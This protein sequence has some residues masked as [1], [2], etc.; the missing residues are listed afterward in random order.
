MRIQ[1]NCTYFGSVNA[2]VHSNSYAVKRRELQDTADMQSQLNNSCSQRN[3]AI[4]MQQARDR[5][6]LPYWE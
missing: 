4:A 5:E 3:A 1:T 6:I 2:Y